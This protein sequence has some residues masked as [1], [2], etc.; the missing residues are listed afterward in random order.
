MENKELNNQDEITIAG[1]EDSD[2]LNEEKSPFLLIY[3]LIVFMAIL[4]AIGFWI[5]KSFHD[6]DETKISDSIGKDV[7]SIV[8]ENTNTST[9]TS[10]SVSTD[11]TGTDEVQEPEEE[12][13]TE[14][15]NALSKLDKERLLSEKYEGVFLKMHN[16]KGFTEKDFLNYRGLHVVTTD[17]NVN[18]VDEIAEAL[19]LVFS[20]S[21]NVPEVYMEID[22]V[23]L[24]VKAGEN[25]AQRDNELERILRYVDEHTD[26]TFEVVYSFPHISY[27]QERTEAEMESIQEIYYHVTNML[28]SRYTVYVYAPG[29]LEWLIVNSKNYDSLFVPNAEIQQSLLI[30]CFCDRNFRIKLEDVLGWFADFKVILDSNNLGMYNFFLPSNSRLV[31]LGD[32]TL[33]CDRKT[34]GVAGT[35]SYMTGARV[36]D[37]SLSELQISGTL[38]DEKSLANLSQSVVKRTIT[39]D[40]YDTAF[41]NEFER[42]ADECQK[43]DSITFVIVAGLN[44]YQT[45]AVTVDSKDKNSI[46]STYG[47]MVSAVKKLKKAY[48]YAKVLIVSPYTMA[49]EEDKP[50]TCAP[51]GMGEAKERYVKAISEAAKRTSSLYLDLA[52]MANISEDNFEKMLLIDGI[53]ASQSGEFEIA[54]AI[55]KYLLTSKN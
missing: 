11:G 8:Q 12:L 9:D 33:D 53:H 51:E 18:T 55:S 50:S 42:F 47:G 54:K 27:W 7:S 24:W 16:L 40:S 32:I 21:R 17:G 19:E 3:A 34:S 41:V 52:E 15:T 14:D 29:N 43:E 6:N 45:G 48:P 13:K 39:K 22:P 38:E 1:I 36:Y 46:L 2:E 49:I 35:V 31:F 30:N 4:V 5:I 25:D 37:L 23:E 20:K 26:T 28:T 10:V 44:D